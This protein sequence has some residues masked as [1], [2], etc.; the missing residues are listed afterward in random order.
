ML[1]ERS[2]SPPMMQNKRQT[3]SPRLALSTRYSPDEMNN[4]PNFEEKKQ[5]LTIFN[6]THISA[7]KRKGTAQCGSRGLGSLHGHG[8]LER[9]GRGLPVGSEGASSGALFAPSAPREAAALLSQACLCVSLASTF[10]P[11]QMQVP[12]LGAHF[13]RRF[14]GLC[15]CYSCRLSDLSAPAQQAERP[16]GTGACHTFLPWPLSSWGRRGPGRFVLPRQEAP[17]WLSL[18][19]QVLL[20]P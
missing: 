7:E 6:L 13:S 12:L 20:G 15:F 4:S 14:G 17:G 18:P 9:Q 8:L 11:F 16:L 19:W 3:P 1:R 10:S 2:P 5:F